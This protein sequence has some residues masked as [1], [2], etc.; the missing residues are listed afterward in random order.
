ME[1]EDDDDAGVGVNVN[2]YINGW[3]ERS[4]GRTGTSTR[5]GRRT[6]QNTTTTT[7]TAPPHLIVINGVNVTVQD[8]VVPA[9][10]WSIPSP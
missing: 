4:E 6:Y 9:L 8:K 1:G 10:F 5:T 3:R 7:T 2:A